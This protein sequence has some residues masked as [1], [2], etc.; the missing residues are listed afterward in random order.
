MAGLEV[1]AVAGF[2]AVAGKACGPFRMSEHAAANG[3]DAAALT[4]GQVRMAL[5]RCGMSVRRYDIEHVPELLGADGRPAYGASPHD[6]LGRPLRGYSGRPLIRVSNL[7]LRD[8]RTAVTT[9][10]HEIAH[11]VSYRSFGHG[12]T[13]AAAERYGRQMYDLFARRWI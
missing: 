5:G 3:Q 1:G 9:I 10:F 6:G 2:A 4:I 8:M 11:H 12:G 13:E 7:A